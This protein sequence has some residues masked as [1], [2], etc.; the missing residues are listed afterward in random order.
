MQLQLVFAPI[1][2]VMMLA[3]VPGGLSSSVRAALL[4]FLVGVPSPCA[5]SSERQRHGGR[6]DGGRNTGDD[7]PEVGVPASVRRLGPLVTASHS[8]ACGSEAPKTMRVI[9]CGGMESR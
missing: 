6:S 3:G 2:Y 4:P 9:V 5:T 8:D 1:V 7:H